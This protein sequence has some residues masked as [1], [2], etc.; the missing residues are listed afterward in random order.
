MQP[1]AWRRL[2]E[3]RESRTDE[4][5][6]ADP[7][8]RAEIHGRGKSGRGGVPCRED[9]RRRLGSARSRHLARIVLRGQ[10]VSPAS[11]PSPSPRNLQYA[12]PAPLSSRPLK[13]R[14]LA[15][16]QH[17][18]RTPCDQKGN[19]RQKCTRALRSTESPKIN[20]VGGVEARRA[21]RRKATG[22]G[23]G[24]APGREGGG[25]GGAGSATML[26]YASVS[27]LGYCPGRG[28]REP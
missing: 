19:S 9:G 1:R 14:Q 18:T 3:R 28:L 13:R 21:R 10:L 24:G 25:G 16:H 15:F 4:G 6:R 20:T 5:A 17:G 23:I 2:C 8:L 27:V 12:S 11:A 22:S 26:R 7:S